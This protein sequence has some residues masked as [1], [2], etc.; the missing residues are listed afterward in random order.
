[1]LTIILVIAG[2][3]LLSVAGLFALMAKDSARKGQSGAGAAVNQPHAS[4][5]ASG[6][7]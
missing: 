3:A 2:A 1:M 5:R 4:G 7:D 6:L